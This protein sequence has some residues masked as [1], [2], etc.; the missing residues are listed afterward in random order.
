MGS[1][2][3]E[4]DASGRLTFDHEVVRRAAMTGQSDAECRATHE[5]LARRLCRTRGD[6]ASLSTLPDTVLR[7]ASQ[8][9]DD[10]FAHG[11]SE[12][13]V[14]WLMIALASDQGSDAWEAATAA[15]FPVDKA[16]AIV[17]ERPVMANT[18]EPELED[19]VVEIVQERVRFAL[20]EGHRPPVVTGLELLGALCREPRGA[21]LLTELSVDQ[22]GLMRAM[23]AVGQRGYYGQDGHQNALRSTGDAVD[24]LDAYWHALM[25]TDVWLVAHT[26]QVAYWHPSVTLDQVADVLAASVIAGRADT[27]PVL[28][29]VNGAPDSM[30]LVSPI[31]MLSVL[32]DCLRRHAWADL[33]TEESVA[34]AEPLYQLVDQLPAVDEDPFAMRAKAD[35][36]EAVLDVVQEANR[37]SRSE[38]MAEL[39]N[40]ALEC[41]QRLAGR[42]LPLPGAELELT[43]SM[44]AT[45]RVLLETGERVEAQRLYREAYLTAKETMQRD[46]SLPARQAF[47]V[48]VSGLVTSVSEHLEPLNRVDRIAV[49]VGVLVPETQVWAQESVSAARGVVEDWPGDLDSEI[50]LIRA[51]RSV[52][53]QV[54][55]SCSS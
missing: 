6:A 8:A 16:R 25:A 23:E 1:Q 49:Q 53:G 33:T 43:R 26:L 36:L 18:E 2:L 46:P 21:D 31:A 14:E 30:N 42:A 24:V 55:N 52:T 54:S 41:R 9:K 29:A 11:R 47:A 19:R 32:V 34:L 44:A 27:N 13:G 37:E 4:R 40:G 39:A 15:G 45:A 5:D 20:G 50:A 12:A 22:A 48:A 35:G 28:G 17:A 51:L 3:T 10:A 38:V 7:A